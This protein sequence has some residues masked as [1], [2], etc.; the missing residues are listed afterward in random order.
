[1]NNGFYDL[2]SLNSIK[3]RRKFLERAIQLS[4]SVTCQSKY[5]AENKNTRNLDKTLSIDLMMDLIDIDSKIDCVDRNIYN[6]DQI[7]D[8][9]YGQVV[10]GDFPAML[11]CEMSLDNLDI[12]VEEFNLK[13]LEI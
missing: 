7:P 10:F 13:L 1:M 8:T 12:L 11:W 4:Y 2:S 6:R 9:D 3:L 5:T